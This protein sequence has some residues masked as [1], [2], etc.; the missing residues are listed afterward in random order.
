MFAFEAEKRGAA[1]VVATDLMPYALERFHFC[2]RVLGSRVVPFFNTSVYELSRWMPQMLEGLPA[3]YEGSRDKFD[4][5]V[6]FGVLYHLRD[7]M[8]AVA[9]IRTALKQTGAALIET[10]TVRSLR[11]IME[12]N[13]DGNRFY[14]DLTTWWAPS[15]AC[16]KAMCRASAL[17]VLP[18][19]IPWAYGLVDLA[20]A[21]QAASASSPSPSTPQASATS[22]CTPC[23]RTTRSRSFLSCGRQKVERSEFAVRPAGQV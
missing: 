6:C 11:P 19:T 15:F 16:L 5:V 17:Q 20:S 21:A 9:Q 2:K 13:T 4:I 23:E 12:F 3:D 18:R 14:R 8:L 22:T 1:Y 7:P 10:A